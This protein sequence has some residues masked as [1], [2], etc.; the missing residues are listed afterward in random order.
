MSETD[1]PT[2]IV[3]PLEEQY[4]VLRAL[5]GVFLEPMIA[6]AERAKLPPKLFAASLHASAQYLLAQVINWE[7]SMPR[8]VARPRCP[9]M[10]TAIVSRARTLPS[11]STE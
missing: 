9:A 4:P 10:C 6:G 1:N 2:A 11:P 3:A 8:S 5:G 7:K